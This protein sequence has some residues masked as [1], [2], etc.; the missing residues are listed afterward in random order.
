MRQLNIITRKVDKMADNL[1][2]RFDK[3]STKLDEASS[4][5][6]AEI[7]KLR[8]GGT[9]TPDQETAL[10]NIEAKANALADISPALEPPPA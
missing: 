7:A 9:L 6:L 2:D 5:I 3:V 10:G 1:K 8:E 4:E